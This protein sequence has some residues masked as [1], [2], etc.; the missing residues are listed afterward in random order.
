VY[1]TRPH[2]TQPL[3]KIGGRFPKANF[4]LRLDRKRSE[5]AF[6]FQLKMYLIQRT[7]GVSVPAN[8][9]FLIWR[10]FTGYK[11]DPL[12]QPLHKIGGRSPSK[13]FIA[14]GS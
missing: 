13:M 11:T 9:L 14:I 2:I 7:F 3:P 4:A 12:A 5:V 6:R 8:K 1:H 10:T